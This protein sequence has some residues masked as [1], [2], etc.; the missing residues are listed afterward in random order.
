[1][2]LKEFFTQRAY[3]FPEK[4]WEFLRM[5]KEAEQRELLRESQQLQETANQGI[6]PGMANA[7]GSSIAHS[8]PMVAPLLMGLNPVTAPYAAPAL[9]VA[10]LDILLGKPIG[11]AYDWAVGNQPA[12]ETSG[13]DRAKELGMLGMFGLAGAATSPLIKGGAKVLG[14]V[15][16][17]DAIGNRIERTR[18]EFEGLGSEIGPIGS[19]AQS[20]VGP[21][22]NLISGG[23]PM[24]TIMDATMIGHAMTG[25]PTIAN[26]ALRELQPDPFARR[27]VEAKI[28]D[29]APTLANLFVDPSFNRNFDF[30][31]DP[32]DFRPVM[33]SG[34]PRPE[35]V[36]PD[37]AKLIQEL[38]AGEGKESPLGTN[39]GGRPII[40][41][42]DIEAR[43]QALDDSGVSQGLADPW[44]S[45]TLADMERVVSG[46]EVGHEFGPGG[47][48]GFEKFLTDTAQNAPRNLQDSRDY[49]RN[50]FLSKPDETAKQFYPATFGGEEA[51]PGG[52]IPFMARNR[53][54]D[55]IERRGVID[56]LKRWAS[57]DEVGFS[58]PEPIRDVE[59]LK[60]LPARL[61]FKVKALIDD[62]RE[63]RKWNVLDSAIDIANAV[64]KGKG[65]KNMPPG[66]P[67]VQS[68]RDNFEKWVDAQLAENS[69]QMTRETEALATG[70]RRYPNL[71]LNPVEI[72]RRETRLNDADLAAAEKEGFQDTSPFEHA[73]GRKDARTIMG[74]FGKLKAN[75]HRFKDMTGKQFLDMVLAEGEPTP[76]TERVQNA[77]PREIPI[78]DA[79]GNLTG[80]SL[81]PTSG[82]N[83]PLYGIL[84]EAPLP[85]AF[86]NTKGILGSRDN[87][88]RPV[89]ERPM[90]LDRLAFLRDE[91]EIPDPPGYGDNQTGPDYQPFMAKKKEELP[92]TWF[93]KLFSASPTAHEK[94]VQDLLDYEKSGTPKGV[95]FPLFEEPYR[96][97]IDKLIPA[98]GTKPSTSRRIGKLGGTVDVADLPKRAPE[99]VIK[100]GPPT[101]PEKGDK[102]IETLGESVQMPIL[103]AKNSVTENG[104]SLGMALAA[105]LGNEHL[106]RYLAKRLNLESRGNIGGGE[107]Y[108]FAPK[109]ELVEKVTDR[110]LSMDD[111]IL[112]E[113]IKPEQAKILGD[114]GAEIMNPRMNH[115]RAMVK[116]ASR[117]LN[118]G[119]EVH[120]PVGP[121][122]IGLIKKLARNSAGR[123]VLYEPA[124]MRETKAAMALPTKYSRV[125]QNFKG[126]WDFMKNK[127]LPDAG[128]NFEVVETTE[129]G[130]GFNKQAAQI[131]LLDRPSGF[132]RS[133]IRD[134]SDVAR[135]LPGVEK[136]ELAPEYPVDQPSRLF[137]QQD[138][139]P[140]GVMPAEVGEFFAGQRKSESKVKTLLQEVQ[141]GDEYNE[142]QMI[143]LRDEVAKHFAQTGDITAEELGVWKDEHG[144]PYKTNVD[145]YSNDEVVALADR[146]S[147]GELKAGKPSADLRQQQF[148]DE[149]EIPETPIYDKSARGEVSNAILEE[150]AQSKDVPA[151]SQKYGVPEK[152]GGVLARILSSRTPDEAMK[153]IDAAKEQLAEATL[154]EFKGEKMP[155]M[156]AA[157]KK[158][159]SLWADLLDGATRLVSRVSYRADQ[160]ILEALQNATKGMTPENKAI[161][162]DFFSN[163]VPQKL[164]MT[165]K[166]FEELH[167]TMLAKSVQIRNAIGKAALDSGLFTGLFLPVKD[168]E[169]L[170]KNGATHVQTPA[171]DS[172]LSAPELAYVKATRKL[173]RY[174]DKIQDAVYKGK[175][176]GSR[177]NYMTQSMQNVAEVDGIEIPAN[178]TPVE[179]QVIG[180]RVLQNLG[181]ANDKATE[182][183]ADKMKHVGNAATVDAKVG[184]LTKAYENAR[185]EILRL[186]PIE[187]AEEAAGHIL[188][189][190]LLR[191]LDVRSDI[192]ILEKSLPGV[193]QHRALTGGYGKYQQQNLPDII[194]RYLHTMDRDTA[195]QGLY[196]LFEETLA[197]DGPVARLMERSEFNEI[198]KVFDDAVEMKYYSGRGWKVGKPT[199]ASKWVDHLWGTQTSSL[200]APNVAAAHVVAG[201][202]TKTLLT[203]PK[204]I[205]LMNSLDPFIKTLISMPG[206]SLLKKGFNSADMMV[207]FYGRMAREVL[208]PDAKPSWLLKEASKRVMSRTNLETLMGGAAAES[209]LGKGIFVEKLGAAGDKAA[210]WWGKATSL[211][212]KQEHLNSM[213][214]WAIETEKAFRTS[215][216]FEKRIADLEFGGNLAK[217]QGLVKAHGSFIKA[218]EN[219]VILKSK[220][221]KALWND[222]ANQGVKEMSILQGVSS[223]FMGKSMLTYGLA[224]GGQN[225]PLYA[226]SILGKQ[227]M[228][229]PV[230]ILG[231]LLKHM[232]SSAKRYEG[233]P[234][235]LMKALSPAAMMFLGSVLA[236]GGP[237]AIQNA[238]KEDQDG[239]PLN[240]K[241]FVESGTKD[242]GVSLTAP[243]PVLSMGKDVLTMASGDP[244]GG[245]S[246][247][248]RKTVPGYNLGSRFVNFIGGKPK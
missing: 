4:R 9:G 25:V 122:T 169:K 224:K 20:V 241:E 180:E 62:V 98:V 129:T 14:G 41:P 97:T 105:E 200:P 120:L 68:L 66:Q 84:P 177:E 60:K 185:A 197:P 65:N 178:L 242:I 82:R 144:V 121:A 225:N 145:L 126:Q 206:D 244:L 85:G 90:S 151:V 228:N 212:E 101:P 21:K 16:G 30:L 104:G 240:L 38:A 119:G 37:I 216:T 219:G 214:I 113:A 24:G 12:P 59:A 48:P 209:K 81:P 87:I 117:L 187:G 226:A 181:L 205:A 70:R 34:M 186:N 19:F 22:S 139:R 128:A 168:S 176:T 227:F 223:G 10:A 210:D 51:S 246:N 6:I 100:R 132:S 93:D 141:K 56:A 166:S 153:W 237:L 23:D 160:Y 107:R 76:G 195:D 182:R 131:P 163:Y 236:Y 94:N 233:D 201:H 135:E 202:F 106:V 231:Q 77:R 125:A 89:R 115:D 18:Q 91:M 55:Q 58:M 155:F 198:R 211:I 167:Q 5:A 80:E 79:E 183:I 157:K 7:L 33:D 61:L 17:A 220:R 69:G 175:K 235:Q 140:S 39:L 88:K 222:I 71:G 208:R 112:A 247:L 32:N 75:D 137:I 134:S 147:R 189:R 46:H 8:G 15:L 188:T 161:W 102:P 95:Q 207:R 191:E 63:E 232:N 239:V 27:G 57:F 47:G 170:M 179:R 53:K 229:Y 248:F 173:M 86:L 36:H 217:V 26:R 29:I 45:R 174:L 40:N 142:D 72:D 243:A 172:Q 13:W 196:D 156:A 165:G 92:R 143:S 138:E 3:M 52:G 213:V 215:P 2:N 118:D 116:N 190:V 124:W 43:W 152:I 221:G 203:T 73:V 49:W 1:M 127:E 111:K 114:M 54:P 110:I 67:G 234:Q 108:E 218:V 154:E 158:D 123:L 230:T 150:L 44:K 42:S 199:F 136:P 109:E 171:M 149:V 238:M 28:R 83:H 245:L 193:I 31:K 184:E 11:Q 164:A 192:E 35:P 162:D 130:G 194:R 96:E 64:D 204:F 148:G 78:R 133:I 74:I 103:R 159:V 99:P 50:L 146:I